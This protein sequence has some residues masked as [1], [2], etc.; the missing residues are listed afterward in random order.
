MGKSSNELLKGYLFLVNSMK[1]K[2]DLKFL[3]QSTIQIYIFFTNILNS[4]KYIK[5]ADQAYVKQ[6]CIASSC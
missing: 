1:A 5:S 6:V 4:Y 2:A 3:E